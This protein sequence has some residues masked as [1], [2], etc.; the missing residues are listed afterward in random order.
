[1]ISWFRY[2]PQTE[3]RALSIPVLV[4]Q[5][6]N[7]I[8]VS[9]EDARRLSAANARAELVLIEHMNHVFKMVVGDRQ[10]NIKTYSDPNLPIAP[11]LGKSIADFI[12]K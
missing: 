2:D 11:E 3:I 7:D 12:L 10:A 9:V 4:V 6:T 1:L 8:Q 5:G